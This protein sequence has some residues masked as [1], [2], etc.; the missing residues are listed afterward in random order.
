MKLHV[1][2]TSGSER[3][4]SMVQIYYR[5]AQAAILTY[6]LT[7]EQS[8]QSLEGWKE[9][10]AKTLDLSEIVLVLVANKCDLAES[11][12]KVSPAKGRQY[13]E[14]NNMLYF[15]T[16]AKTGQGVPELF[17]AL[18]EAVYKRLRD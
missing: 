4:K 18:S 2:D 1:W 16:S 3:F 5:D 11:E 10:L 17:N 12:R 13:A 9:E 15:E 14:A 8:F 7:S 6:D